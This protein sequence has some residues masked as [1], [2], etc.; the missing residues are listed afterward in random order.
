MQWWSQA[1]AA[2]EA[3]AP[4]LEVRTRDGQ[5]S[6]PAG[7][8][9]LVGRDPEAD[10]VVPDAC[11][12]WQHA[13]LRREGDRWVLADNGS[14]NGTFVNEQR[15]TTARLADGDTIGFGDTTFRLTGHELTELAPAAPAQRL[16][17]P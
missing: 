13:V 3:T 7:P 5:R 4:S 15:V 17:S 1:S 11:V 10:I 6:L 9:Y 2:P 8:A 14:T 16:A 12:S